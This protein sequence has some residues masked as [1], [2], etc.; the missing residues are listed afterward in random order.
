MKLLEFFSKQ[1]SDEDDAKIEVDLEKDLMGFIL[2]DDE[3]YKEHIFPLVSKLEKGKKVDAE[4]FMKAVNQGCL[5]FYKEKDFKKDPN[6]MFPLK[7]RKKMA[8]NLLT[9]NTKG[10]K[11]DE[12]SRTA[13]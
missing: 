8:G 10:S 5:K 6:K 11:K 4:D 2:D 3:L 12:D 7:M 13:Y 9:I 1:N